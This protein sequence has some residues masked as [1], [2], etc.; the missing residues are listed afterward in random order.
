MK[1]L[2]E[3][4]FSTKSALTRSKL[5]SRKSR[6]LRLES[7]ER[8]EVR[9]AMTDL[10]AYRP[11]T[12]S[13]DYTRY[14]VPDALE[15]DLLQGPGIRINGDDDNRNGVADRLDKSRTSQIDDDLIRVDFTSNV[16]LNQLTWTN[17]L[18]IWRT[19]DKAAAYRNGELVFPG[20][21]LWVEYVGT[22]HSVG[23]NTSLNVLSI[24]M[25]SYATDQIVFHTFKSDVIV[26][27]GAFQDPKSLQGVFGMA[28]TLYQ[29]GY[30]VHPYRDTAVNKAGTGADFGQ[31]AAYDEVRS[32][33]QQRG[34]ENIAMVGM[35]YGGGAVHDLAAAIDKNPF[36]RGRLQYTAYVDAVEHYSLPPRS[37]R[38]LP[39]GSKFH[40]NLYQKND[41]A[42]HGDSVPGA[43][44]NIDVSNWKDNKGA[45]LNHGIIDKNLNVQ[46]VILPSLRSKLASR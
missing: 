34:V 8:R 21:T 36:L 22:S 40:D 19:P 13:I 17:N 10:A 9:A 20:Q 4:L 35:S 37:E 6:S 16:T 12:D 15:A 43:A 11:M 24:G 5:P 2:F 30:D 33:I 28:V 44:R 25:N 39:P 23:A 1:S 26:V 14:R 7:L 42:V 45:K 46:M 27:G 38:R 32:A 41:P 18:A 3:W 29:Q 31:P